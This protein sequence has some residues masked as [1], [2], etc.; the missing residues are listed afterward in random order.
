MTYKTKTKIAII[1]STGSIGLSALDV[2]R[3]H[4]NRFEIVALAAGSNVEKLKLQI[5]E[6]KPRFAALADE[7]AALQLGKISPNVEFRAGEEGVASL[8]EID[9]VDIV[10]VSVVGIAGLEPALKTLRAGK[11]LAIATKEVFVAA[12]KLILDE[13][14]KYNA[15]ILPVDSEHCAIFQ[16]MQAAGTL[17]NKSVERL[18]LTASGGPFFGKKYDELKNVTPMQALAHPTWDMG[19]KISIDSATL[20]NKGLEVIEARW[21]FDVPAEQIDVVIHPQSIIHSLVDFCDG[22][23]I[24]QMSNPDMRM[25]ILYALTFPERAPL[26]MPPLDLSKT[27]NLTF[28]DPDCNVFPCLELAYAALKEGG[29]VPAVLNAANEI[30]VQKFLDGQISFLEIPSHIE[31]KMGKCNN[32]VKPTLN[33]IIAADKWAREME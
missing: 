20:M 26:K 16:C 23:A 1:G 10:L 4:K 21:L 31:K 33:D 14:K 13:A 8:C 29:I 24:A 30:A 12:G 7:N 22:A 6:F 9:D 19:S 32:I 2:I 17:K 3:E 25:P 11:R 5:D 18:I 27:G 28:F 15:E